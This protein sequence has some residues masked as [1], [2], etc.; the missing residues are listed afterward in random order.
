MRNA[1]SKTTFQTK[2]N[3]SNPKVFNQ[4]LLRPQKSTATKFSLY[5][6]TEKEENFH[7]PQL[8]F[9]KNSKKTGFCLKYLLFQFNAGSESADV[10]RRRT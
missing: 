4:S 9:K 7:F 8:Y 6:Q 5:N 3:L 10:I 2:I 1:P